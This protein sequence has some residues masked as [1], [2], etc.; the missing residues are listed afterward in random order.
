MYNHI[1]ITSYNHLSC[2]FRLSGPSFFLCYL[3]HCLRNAYAATVGAYAAHPFE[4]V[5]TQTQRPCKPTMYVCAYAVTLP[6]AFGRF[7]TE[8]CLRDHSPINIFVNWH[9]LQYPAGAPVSRLQ[10]AHCNLQSVT[11]ILQPHPAAAP[12]PRFQSALYWH[13]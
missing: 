3:R 10:S 11:D 2:V 9:A 8:L 7:E 1:E 12:A 5:P 4:G 13:H 6:F